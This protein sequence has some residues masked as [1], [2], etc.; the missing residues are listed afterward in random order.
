MSLAQTLI[1]AEC[2]PIYGKPCNLVENTIDSIRHSIYASK[3]ESTGGE[4]VGECAVY[5]ASES[6]NGTCSN[7]Q[8]PADLGMIQGV[9]KIRL[10]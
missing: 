8:S 4:S 3:S 6:L 5:M 10:L 1:I 7:R 2:S 9:R